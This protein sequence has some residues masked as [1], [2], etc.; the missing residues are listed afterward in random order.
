[1]SKIKKIKFGN[2]KIMN[3]GFICFCFMFITLGFAALGVTLGISGFTR[4]GKIVFDVHFENV[5]E[6]NGSI[7]TFTPATIREND[8]TNID[9]G[10]KFIEPGQFYEFEVDIVNAGTLDAYLSSFG[11]AGL[12]DDVKKYLEFSYTYAEGSEIKVNDLLK[13]GGTDVIKVRIELKYDIT[14]D[15]IKGASLP[16]NLTFNMNYAQDNGDGVE[17]AVYLYDKLLASYTHTD[18]NIFTYDSYTSGLFLN[19]STTNDQYPMV[20]FHGGK[21]D[22]PG[23]VGLTTYATSMPSSEDELNN[24]ILFAGYCWKIIRTTEQGGTKL[25]YNG[26]PSINFEQ[27]FEEE[28]VAKLPDYI[29]KNNNSDNPFDFSEYNEWVSTNHTDNSSSVIEFSVSSNAYYILGYDIYS[30]YNHDFVTI[31][32]N[33]KQISEMLSGYDYDSVALGYLTVDDV[34]KVEYSKDDSEEVYN[35]DMVY[36]W[37]IKLDYEPK[38]SCANYGADSQITDNRE[39]SLRVSSSKTSAIG[40]VIEDVYSSPSIYNYN[41]QSIAS[42]GYMYGDIDYEQVEWVDTPYI[43]ASDVSYNGTTYTLESPTESPIS[44]CESS[45]QK[46]TCKMDKIGECSEVYYVYYVDFE[47][48]K[49][50]ASVKTADEGS[51]DETSN[52]Y[53]IKLTDGKTIENYIEESFSNDLSSNVKNTIDNWFRENL[54]NEVDNDKKDYQ[55]YLEDAIWCNNRNIIYGGFLKDS[56]P[57]VS[58][59]ESYYY[60]ISPRSYSTYE[61]DGDKVDYSEI[62]NMLFSCPNKNDRFTKNDI[63]NGNGDLDYPVGMLTSGEFVLGG[64]YSYLASGNYY[65]TMTP[66]YGPG[67]YNESGMSVVS[68]SGYLTSFSV[69]Y[70]AGVRP[71]IVLK[72]D[73]KLKRGDGSLTNP[74]EIKY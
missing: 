33:G 3:I 9:F 58:I 16:N 57:D 11:V 34:V 21:S 42:V 50:P 36:F 45:E 22:Y 37:M 24:N 17:H 23:E 43:Y 15:D 59:F 71:A 48:C 64:E 19:S 12:S 46:Y 52:V 47:Y 53:A 31:S 65:W 20:Y 70:E 63:I 55:E 39:K 73:V 28:N 74:Y 44:L 14:F 18:E 72:H 30:E 67:P 29:V 35:D 66:L 32:L 6:S 60:G 5:V 7:E 54:T 27:Y 61:D 41:A 10:L 2:K 69:G 62:M 13:A 26:E 49:Y 1:M 51:I 25:L 4:I 8:K 56:E 68:K 40:A 38:P